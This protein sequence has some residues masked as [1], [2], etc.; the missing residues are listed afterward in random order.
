MKKTIK[1]FFAAAFA[2]VSAACAREEIFESEM[3]RGESRTFT[4]AIDEDAQTRT[5]ITKQGKTVWKEG[6]RILVSNGTESDTL[7]VDSKFAGQK[8]F[9]FTTTLQGKIYVVYPYNYVK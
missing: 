4:C 2:I 8:Y 6:D 7:T 9:E 5:E 1:M 3:T